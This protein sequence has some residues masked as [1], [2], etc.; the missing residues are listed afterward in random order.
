MP[1]SFSENLKSYMGRE[2][3]SEPLVLNAPQRIC[4]LE[5]MNEVCKFRGFELF[6]INVR[7][8]HFHAVVAAMRDPD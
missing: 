8:N 3:K 7:T 5:I 2:M 6:A 4:V 1:T